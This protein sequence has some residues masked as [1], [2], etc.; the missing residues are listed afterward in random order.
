MA[1]KILVV[2]DEEIIRDSISYILDSEG[3]EVDK[4]ENGKI[5]YDKIKEKHFDLV[6][7]DIEMPVMKGTEL[8]EKIKTLAPQ[9]AVIIITAFGSLDTAI[10]ALRNGASDYILK[11]VEFDELLIK[12]KRLFEIKDLLIENKVLREE[13]NRKYD[14]DNIV[15]KS[16]AIKKVFD[17]IQA[18]AETDSTVLIS[19][20]S[21]T[22]KELVARAIHYRSKR[23][24]KPF[25]AVN[26]G[27]ISENLIE[28]ELFGHKKGAFTGAISDKEGFIKAADGGTLFLDE[29]SEMPPQLQ[30]KLLRAIQE[31][32]YTPVGTTQS[33]PVNVRFVAT[34]N[35][36]LEEEVKAGRFR[37]DLYYRLNVVEIHLPS[38]KEREEDIP[39]LADHFLNKYRKEL[40]KNIKGIDN[41][42]MRVLLAHEWRGEVRELE[43]AIE[44]AVIF[45]RGEYISVDDL[46]P[47]FVPDRETLTTNFSGSLE[48]SVRK[49]ERDFI[50]RVLE[51][52]NFNKEKTAEI[53]N[54]GLST[55]YRKLKEL[56]IKI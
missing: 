47:T 6:I 40:N 44:R 14:F 21:G 51:S 18:V 1:F 4:A 50:M 53:L 49:F 45:C 20:N 52:N 35:R 11:P 34:T 33:L 55:L 54:I 26:C 12:V 42:A 27:A 29:I 38:L 10:T 7:T 36:N 25:I 24:N 28:S 22:G 19:G 37:E 39:L 46:P 23:K 48:D 31:K 16:P 5:A 9:T 2:D 43:N 13:I 30:V 41:N 15:G 8:L 17:M 56:D 32:E 3:Y